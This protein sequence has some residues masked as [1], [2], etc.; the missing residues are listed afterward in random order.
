MQ[1]TNERC[2]AVFGGGCFWCT[3]A[4]FE[5]IK[6][7][8]EVKSGYSGGS[9]QNPNYKEVCDGNSGHVECV[10]IIYD[11]NVIDFEN[12]VRIFLSMHDPTTPNRQGADVGSQYRSV[13]FYQDE[14]QHKVA[15]ETI[16]EFEKRKVYKMPIVTDVQAAQIFYEAEENH[17]DFYRNNSRNTYCQVVI[18]PK[19]AKLRESFAEFMKT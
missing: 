1:E 17:Q 5:N 7:V 4:I 14:R 12:L 10:Q 19:L 18:N 9:T 3:E 8:V 13:I 15:T 11:R 6:G 16:A 2:V